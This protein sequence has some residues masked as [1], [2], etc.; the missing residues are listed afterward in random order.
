LAYIA[1]IVG[2]PQGI[3]DQDLRPHPHLLDIIIILISYIIK[4]Y[5]M[6]TSPA[7]ARNGTPLQ[8]VVTTLVPLG[9]M[10]TSQNEKK[11]FIFLK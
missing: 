10:E 4:L 6:R 11:Y 7:Q 9:G 1:L 3:L 8:K 2:D 5:K